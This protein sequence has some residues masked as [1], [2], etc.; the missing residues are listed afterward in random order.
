MRDDQT[1]DQAVARFLEHKRALGRKY[2]SEEAGLRLL[3]RFAEEHG[4]RRLQELTPAMLDD[5]LASRPRSRPRS[6]NHLLG[7]VGCLLD[8]AVR[9]QVLQV[10]PLRTRRRRVSADRIPFIFDAVQARRLLEA[11]AALSDLIR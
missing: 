2:R 9:Q 6:F 5:F 4:V 11:A 7:V 8:W 10:S 1:I 3:M